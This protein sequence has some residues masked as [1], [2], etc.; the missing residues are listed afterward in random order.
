MQAHVTKDNLVNCLRNEDKVMERVLFTW[1]SG[2]KGTV[3]CH[4][5]GNIYRKKIN[6][7]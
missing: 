6:T 5:L 3:V 1:D 4:Y 2:E 7:K